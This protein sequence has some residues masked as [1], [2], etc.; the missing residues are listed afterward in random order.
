MGQAEALHELNIRVASGGPEEGQLAFEGQLDA[1]TLP[2]AWRES[3]TPLRQRTP[4]RLI[5]DVSQLGYCDGAGLGLFAELR[6][7]M[8]VSG[9][10]LEIRGAN[11]QLQAMI[12]MSALDDP[13]AG[14]L[15]SV[16]PMSLPER[17]G[18][19]VVNLLQDI[20]ILL[21]FV[22]QLAE[23][24]LWSILRP[25]RIRL[26]DLLDL[27][28][29]AG[30]NALPVVALLGFLV[31]LILAFQAAGP[32]R[33]YGAQS[34]IPTLVGISVVK[35]FG[36]LITAIVL[37]GR[38]G[39][40]FAAEIGTMKVTE[41]VSALE[42]LGLSPV[43]FLVAPRVLAAMIVTP[44]LCIYNM[45]LAIIG[46]YC[47]MASLGYSLAFYVNQL[48]SSISYTTF[49]AGI[50]K[51]FVF[52]IIVAAIG[53]QRGLATK[54]GPGAVGDSTTR[55]VVAGIVLIILADAVLGAIYYV[56]GI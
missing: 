21:S 17:T 39:A 6:R 45:V 43:Q 10:Q 46:G 11:E 25:R 15:A 16:P 1:T 31:G 4:R 38:S 42:T 19:G 32:L 41:E 34:L 2:R 28:D 54:S 9:G 36:P 40:A 48:V 7:M 35:E 27:A 51:A 30:T 55:A 22:G 53:C 23:T 13:T 18:R 24:L 26:G 50:F 20:G 5:V 44:V 12:Q 29:K 47:M 37:A 49:L 56:L 52:S 3:V 14:Q 33:D 8:A